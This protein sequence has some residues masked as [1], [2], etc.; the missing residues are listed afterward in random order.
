MADNLDFS[1]LWAISLI[2]A[3]KQDKWAADKYGK[4]RPAKIKVE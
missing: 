4:V 1:I 3:G 2:D